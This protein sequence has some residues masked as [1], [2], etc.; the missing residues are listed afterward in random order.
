MSYLINPNDDARGRITLQTAIKAIVF[1]FDGTIA[2]TMPV[3]E[4]IAVE[5]LQKNYG[6][7][8]EFARLGY[9]TTTGLP[10]CQQMELLYPK[11][12]LNQGV[13]DIFEKKKLES[14]FEQPLFED[15]I[16][17]LDNLRERGY[18]TVISSS[19][20]QSIIEEYCKREGIAERLDLIL[21]FA[22][23]FEKGKAHFTRTC[24]VF[25]LKPSNILFVGDSLKDA[26]RALEGQVAFI[27]RVGMFASEDF[28]K[29]IPDCQIV[30]KLKELLNL[31]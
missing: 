2:D 18:I 22:P 15:T 12:P 27:G 24:E 5:L 16:D 6:I 8:K 3:L 11:N 31:L 25:D 20:I 13:I 4:R 29:I 17:V 1:D 14:I 21:G 7:S 26:E 30:F 19:T 28:A 9:I 23:G 10:F